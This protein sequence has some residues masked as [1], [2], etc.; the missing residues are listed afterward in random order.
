MPKV[1]RLML[2]RRV[3]RT[4]L[5][6]TCAGGVT[7]AVATAMSNPTSGSPSRAIGLVAAGPPRAIG[8]TTAS[9]RRAAVRDAKGLLAG[10]VPPVGAVLQSRGTRIGAHAPL[11]TTAFASAVAYSTWTVPEDPASV[12]SFVESHL[13]SGSKVVSTGSGGPNPSSQSVIRSWPSVDD[14]LDVRWLE[15]DVASGS[16]GGIQLHAESQSQWVIT[17]PRDEQ[18]PAGVREIDVTSS[19]PGKP[20][21]VSRQVTNRAEV[22]RLV[23]LFDALG[24]VQPGAINCPEFSPNPVVDI[25]F[26]GGA[27]NRVVAD[28]SVSSEASF[29]WPPDVP[30]WACFPVAFTVRGRNWSPL[31]GNVITPIERLLRVNLGS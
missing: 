12:L 8:P 29:S 4:V 21:F 9:N 18:I 30:G 5:L 23:T 20:P 24:I 16:S 19:W 31:S 17:R 11:L 13:P 3:L 25:E 7:A 1:V 26:R 2:G 28:A 15:I 6:L 22:R 14:V 10:V 27:T